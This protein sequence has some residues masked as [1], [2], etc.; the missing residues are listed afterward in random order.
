MM[1]YRPIPRVELEETTELISTHS[2]P[3]LYEHKRLL[4]HIDVEVKNDQCVNFIEHFLQN[5]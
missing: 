1:T 4:N 2:P 5:T 3:S